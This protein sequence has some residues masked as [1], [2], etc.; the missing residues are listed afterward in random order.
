MERW[1][2]GGLMTETCRQ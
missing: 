1:P 2:D